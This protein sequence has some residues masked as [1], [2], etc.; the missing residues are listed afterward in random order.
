MRILALSVL[1][2]ASALV[3]PAS[4]FAYESEPQELLFSDAYD[5]FS[6]VEYDTGYWPSGSPLSVRFFIDSA[7][8]AYT[9]MEAESQLTW[10]DPLTQTLVPYPGSG[11]FALD[12]DLTI[13]AQVHFD[14]WGYTDTIDIWREDLQMAEEA[15]FDPFLL[16]GSAE[17][18]VEVAT[19]AED[20]PPLEYRYAVGAGV[21]LLFQLEYFPQARAALT[22]DRIETGDAVIYQEGQS[23]LLDVPDENP[24]W[25]DLASV[26]YAD[27][28]AALDLVLKP[29][30]E[31]CVPVMGCY[32]V[33]QFEIP[34]ELAGVDE[35]RAFPMVRYT[36][37]L[38]ALENMVTSYDFGDV[39]VD[40]LANMHVEFSNI[41]RQDLEAWMHVE[42]SDALEVYPE[43]VH[44]TEGNIDGV[45]VSFAPTEADTLSAVLVVESND[46]M[47]PRIEIPLMGTGYTPDN[48]CGLDDDQLAKVS[49][50]GCSTNSPANLAWVALLG[51]VGLVLRRR[52]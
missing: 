23:I 10:P 29:N 24:G 1:L 19:R 12:T 48:P 9:E 2:P 4:A 36:H 38:P 52:R 45:V 5:V 17:R 51:A 28:V 30:L 6:A 31:V 16:E 27:M 11:W 43:Y 14:L 50:C 15:V 35:E 22:G 39:P 32:E 41:G 47:R 40:G 25:I 46:P 18:T 37:P 42:G 20:Y 34:I 3:L 8:A 44:A 33:A 26:Y 13:A 7:G 21:D 49:A